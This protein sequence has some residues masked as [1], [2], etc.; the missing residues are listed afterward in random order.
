MKK[1]A[2]QFLTCVFLFS[3]PFGTKKL[4]YVIFSETI[5][6]FQE[7]SSVFLFWTDCVLLTFL[8]FLFAYQET[9]SAFISTIK[10]SKVF[11]YSLG[12][13]ILFSLISIFSASNI[14]ISFASFFHLI[15]AVL[16]G[17]GIGVL[18]KTKYLKPSWV[19]I[20]LAFSALI[21][22]LVAIGQF[23][24]QKSVGFSLLGESIIGITTKGVARM[25][26]DGGRFLRSY[27]TMVHANI[28]AAF[29]VLGFL[30][31]L[32]LFLK[33]QKKE[34]SFIR[35]F[36]C[37]GVI[38][39]LVALIFTFSRSGW[40]ATVVGLLCVL[41]AGISKKQFRKQT[42][43]F[44]CFIV[45]V[46]ILLFN[47]FGKFI[48]TRVSMSTLQDPS[49]DYRFKY[50]RIGIEIFSE[51]L[52]GV[53]IANQVPYGIEKKLY[54]AEDIKT[55]QNFQPV[56][57]LYLLIGS[58]IGIFGLISFIILLVYLIWRTFRAVYD[59]DSELS[60]FAIISLAGI[61]VFLIFGLVDHFSWDLQAGRLM[62]WVILGMMI[63]LSPRR[64]M[65]RTLASDLPAECPR[66]STDR[67]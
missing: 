13:L 49:I 3:I 59:S 37:A 8:I 38:L 53:G 50:N 2:L 12:G 43:Y 67:A 32:Y 45:V 4:L 9:R 44:F 58:E 54:Q 22:A 15:L 7:F 46:G 23:V 47:V 42:I 19:F 52:F 10:S 30:A 55:I 28:L 63:S 57:N 39:I 34:F 31:L 35:I 21:Q 29:L 60:L 66:S 36:S 65:D 14:L 18:I 6:K 11:Q 61:L 48:V 1:N 40:I 62:F 16:G 24:Y 25:F 41:I 20:T 51:N 17:I 56:H 26:I 33:E 27:G 64:S 5:P